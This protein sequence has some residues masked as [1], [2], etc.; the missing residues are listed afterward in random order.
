MLADKAKGSSGA[1]GGSPGKQRSIYK[2]LERALQGK[3]DA[4]ATPK[5]KHPGDG[6]EFKPTGHPGTEA[7][8]PPSGISVR[9]PNDLERTSIKKA[10]MKG[11]PLRCENPDLWNNIPQ[12]IVDS[13]K[14]IVTAAIDGDDSLYDYQMCTNARLFKAQAQIDSL[15]VKL[16]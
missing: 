11:H 14:T 5:Q 15:N 16:K 4:N 1:P 6:N 12:C 13:I 8:R 10:L 7:E 3:P 9:E 2:H